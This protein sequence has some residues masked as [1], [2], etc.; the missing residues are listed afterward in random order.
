MFGQTK[1]LTAVRQL[2]NMASG[3]L[4][5]GY[6]TFGV[7]TML[8]ASFFG[9]P[10]W[11]APEYHPIVPTMEGTT[12]TLTGHDL[13]IE[14]L[15][16]VARYGARV[17]YGPGV[18]QHAS[19]VLGLKLEADA[20]G[21][22][23]YGINRGPGAQREEKRKESSI[24]PL[25]GGGALPEISDEELVRATI[26][27]AANTVGFAAGTPEESQMLLDLLN[28]RITP[29][30]YSRGTLGEADFPAVSN[31][32]TAAVAGE[33]EAYYKGV[34]MTAA[35]A[36]RQAGLK[37]LTTGRA[38][39][40]AENAYGDALAALV[41]A[42]ARHVL[43][44]TDLI[45]AMAKLGM[46]S[47][48]TGMA[49]LVQMA[50]P[51]KW[52]NW[53]AARVLDILK[54]SYLFD[55][56]PKRILT[57]PQSMMSFYNRSGSAWQA[58]A[59][60]RDSVL[61]QINSADF[62]P[63]ALVGASPQDY[64]ELSTPQFMKFYVKGGA[65]SHGQHGYVVSIS[66]YDPYPLANNVE[67]FTNA[68]ANMDA[69]VA[70]MIERFTDRGPT[71]F[72]TGVKPLDVLTAEQF[73]ASPWLPYSYPVVMDLW[74]EVQSQSRSITPEGSAA[75]LGVAD[76]ESVTRLKGTRAREVVDL[77]MKL[78]AYDLLT[79]TY[80]MDVRKV[81]NPTRDFG[82]A[83]TAV[84]TAFRKV[85]PW[86]QDP[87]LRPQIPYGIVA[88][89]F[90]KSTPAATFYPGGPAMPE[91]EGDSSR[92]KSEVQDIE[93]RTSPNRP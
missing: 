8:G 18:V 30:A 54:G 6:A 75:D 39:G 90:L 52:I 51:F 79:T 5:R 78:L 22:P 13:T 86:Q 33:G 63:M 55:G 4:V 25:L 20:E 35:G 21:I 77:T 24:P 65:L 41:V 56:D 46:N 73:Q 3:S 47:N 93:Q 69:L 28:K 84:W 68:L 32:I 43:E 16:A 60:L 50:R 9:S 80:W 31:N 62:G 82:Q 83:P 92:S 40:G 71:A 15:I 87:K 34:R 23:V 76:T 48:V 17:Q 64:W 12:V 67:A 59:A 88:Y 53:D 1:L 81:Q 91:T 7:M 26:L 29:V 70:Q 58:W 61:L 27:I 72:F 38:R 37:P 42:D 57:D 2:T 45:F 36:L 10:A 74:A 14:Q 19:D 49:T 66:N 85:L 89:D 44:W 11:A